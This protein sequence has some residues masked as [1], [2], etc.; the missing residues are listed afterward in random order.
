MLIDKAF[1]LKKTKLFNELDLDLLL[2]VADKM[3]P[4]FFDKA[5]LIF[6]EGS[7]AERLY[8]IFQGKVLCCAKELG[9]F[10]FFGDEALFN[11]KPRTY[12]AQALEKTHLLTLSKSHLLTILA[13]C[14]TV[15]LS[16]LQVYTTTCPCRFV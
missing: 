10:D 5:A 7:E 8:L 2:A 13:E 16:L 14:P 4:L 15:A 6:E 12:L 3:Q 1:F 11:E 9:P